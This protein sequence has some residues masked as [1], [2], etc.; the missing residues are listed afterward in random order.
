MSSYGSPHALLPP[1]FLLLL[2][3]LLLLKLFTFSAPLSPRLRPEALSP[4]DAQTCA[5]TRSDI[6]ARAL[7]SPP[8]DTRARHFPSLLCPVLFLK[9]TYMCGWN[10][11]VLPFVPVTRS[12]QLVR[13]CLISTMWLSY[14]YAKIVLLHVLVEMSSA[15]SGGEKH[16]T[17][18]VVKQSFPL[19]VMAYN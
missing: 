2:L 7:T 11:S 10:A 1:S 16:D 12:C 14:Y 3:P 6:R 5:L 19:N 15:N 9:R 17:F 18:T 8:A 13:F 4:S